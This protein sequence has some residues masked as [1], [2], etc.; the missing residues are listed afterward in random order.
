MKLFKNILLGSD[1]QQALEVFKTDPFYYFSMNGLAEDTA[2]Q[3]MAASIF[4]LMQV[5]AVCFLVL[6]TLCAV[7]KWAITP[8]AR[9]SEGIISV[10]SWKLIIAMVLAAFIEI[11]GFVWIL[12]DNIQS[13]L[14]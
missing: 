3:E 1:A 5:I 9:K 14:H 8:P 10:L 11:V 13:A 7:I 4:Q 2:M 6:A 12:F